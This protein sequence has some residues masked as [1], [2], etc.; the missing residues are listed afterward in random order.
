MKNLGLIL[1]AC[2]MVIGMNSCGSG[3][4]TA[5]SGKGTQVSGTINGA[6]NLQA[7]LD[8]IQFDNSNTVVSSVPIDGSGKFQMVMEDGIEAGIYRLRIGAVKTML[9]F[10]G[11]EKGVA[12][13]GDLAT[14]PK[15][16]VTIEGS[17]SSS[18][19]ANMVKDVQAGNMT[20]DAVN[21]YAKN[22]SDV[23]A[24][25]LASRSLLGV[26]EKY[27][28]T[29]QSIAAKMSQSLAGTQYTKDFSTYASQ[30]SQQIAAKKVKERIK[31]GQPAPDIK[32]DSPDGK[33]YAL[34]D[35]KGKVVLLDFWASWCGPCRKANPHVVQLYD[36][37]NK[38]GFEVFSVS[39]DGI[40]PRSR[41]GKSPDQLAKQLESS[42]QRWIQAIEKD[43]LKWEYHV[44][45]LQHWK[46]AP[47]GV[48]GVSGIPR[49]FMID[50]D[51]IIAAVNPR[52]AALEAE[53]KKLL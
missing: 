29:V 45:D 14:M 20:L 40:N 3:S 1:F 38:E 28:G 10:D 34:S 18:D 36:K 7:F 52:G 24:A 33:S 37:Y 39:L 41:G 16:E 5:F 47:A 8:K 51:G 22:S 9:V 30:L 48:Y 35:L 44:S 53:L 43:N 25:A 32:L 21:E 11:T 23:L 31:V 13:T 15:G 26:N 49:T 2:I 27:L 12:I 42:K 6:A 46:S 50:K 17:K 4:G 19:F